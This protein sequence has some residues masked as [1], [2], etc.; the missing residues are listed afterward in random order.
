[1][2]LLLTNIPICNN[3]HFQS[4]KQNSLLQKLRGAMVNVN[5][6]FFFS[7]FSSFR[8]QC[9]HKWSRDQFWDNERFKDSTEEM[10]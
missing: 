1:M 6:Y 7:F 8:P 5:K 2:A 3:G 10:F 9:I 4:L